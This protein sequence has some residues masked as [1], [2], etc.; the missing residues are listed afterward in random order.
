MKTLD[1]ILLAVIVI[2]MLGTVVMLVIVEQQN[3]RP[4]R[5]ALATRLY[6]EEESVRATAVAR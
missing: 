3:T 1:K 6:A 5:N 4:E 2:I